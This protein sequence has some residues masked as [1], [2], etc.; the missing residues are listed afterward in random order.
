M[1][2]S[3]SIGGGFGGQKESERQDPKAFPRTAELSLLFK[4]FMEDIVSSRK[5][6]SYGD[7]LQRAATKLQ[8]SIGGTY[9]KYKRGVERPRRAYFGE[10][11]G[12]LNRLISETEANRKPVNI[13][14]GGEDLMTFT[15]HTGKLSNLVGQRAGLE[16]DYFTG[17]SGD[18]GYLD[19]LRR[20]QAQAGLMPKQGLL[21]M[22]KDILLPLELAR[23]G[24]KAVDSSGR[25]L[26]GNLGGAGVGGTGGGG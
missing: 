7:A 6:G 3:L 17:A 12:L 13:G 1:A 18:I 8:Q 2:L 11:R 25:T 20:E 24:S 4:K 22:Y 19:Q 15:P 23:Y 26:G 14:F 10:N 9:G 5:G 16:G 21:S